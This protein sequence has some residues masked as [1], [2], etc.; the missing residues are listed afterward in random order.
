[1]EVVIVVGE[2]GLAERVL[3]SYQTPG[4]SITSF[5]ITDKVIENIH[6][7]AYAVSVLMEAIKKYIGDSNGIF[8]AADRNGRRVSKT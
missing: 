5:Q 6:L 8:R 7:R 2:N 3:H 4:V 1:M